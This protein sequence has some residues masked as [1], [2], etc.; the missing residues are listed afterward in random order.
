MEKQ[1][2]IDDGEELYTFK[3]AQGDVFAKF[4]FN[5]ADTGILERYD[6]AVEN[7]NAIKTDFTNMTD[8]DAAKEIVNMD[9]L[10][11]EQFNVI[12][13]KNVSDGMFMRYTPLTLFPNGQFYAEVVAEKI[14]DFIRTAID[15]RQ[16]LKEKKKEKIRNDIA[17][18]NA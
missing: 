6:K 9:N 4:S 5:P 8:E 17:A 2:V 11:K 13:G 7:L 3:N 10:I 16:K 1:F 18:D 15:E 12:C 14:G